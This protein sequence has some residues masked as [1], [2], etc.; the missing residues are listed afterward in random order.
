KFGR[1]CMTL[2]R[3]ISPHGRAWQMTQNH[4]SP[5]YLTKWDEVLK[6]G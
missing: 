5:S 4:K 1:D 3:L 2:G 6:V